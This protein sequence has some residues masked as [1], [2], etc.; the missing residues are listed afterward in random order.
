MHLSCT[1]DHKMDM[2][3]GIQLRKKNSSISC[4]LLKQERIK[5]HLRQRVD[6]ASDPRARQWLTRSRYFPSNASLCL[7]LVYFGGMH[8]DQ[9][10]V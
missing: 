9:V 6:E 2:F 5:M 10:T 4:D 8:W 1:V 3:G 7:F